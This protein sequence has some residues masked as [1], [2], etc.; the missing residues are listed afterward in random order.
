MQTFCRIT[1]MKRII[2]VFTIFCLLI[3]VTAC[4]TVNDS[5]DDTKVSDGIQITDDVQITDALGNKTTVSKNSKDVSLYGSFSECWLLSGGK[6]VGVTEDAITEHELDVGDAKTVG[7]VKHINLESV[8]ALNPDYVILSADLTAHLSLQDSLDSMGLAYG[9]FKVHTFADYKALMAQFCG[10]NGRSDLFEQNVT[11]VESKITEIMQKIPVTDKSVLL[12]RAF[13]TGMKAKRDETVA[14]MILSEFGLY[15]IAD[16]DNSLLEDLSLEEIVKANPDYIFVTTMGD[17]Q[18][19]YTY[20]EN[21]LLN[22]PAFTE[23]GAVKGANY[24]VLP[25]KLFHYKPNNRWSKSYEHLAKLVF[26]E[27]FGE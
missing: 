11:A 9:Y 16:S 20:L 27:I 2:A 22:H 6:L 18:D 4:G 25:K 3:S 13:S 14:G 12:I 1:N 15:N 7:T 10:I 19:A 5:S 26:P 23:L 8:V 24:H 17:E 21:N